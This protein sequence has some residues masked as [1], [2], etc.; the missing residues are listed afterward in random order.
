MTLRDYNA[1]VDLVGRNGAEDRDDKSALSVFFNPKSV[2]VV[3][4]SS[5]P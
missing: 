4:A 5:D 2:T 3:G 1:A